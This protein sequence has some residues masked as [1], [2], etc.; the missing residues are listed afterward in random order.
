[1]NGCSEK[2][3]LI[4]DSHRTQLIG[5]LATEVNPS[6]ILVHCGD[7]VDDVAPLACR[8]PRRMLCVKGNNDFCS[9]APREVI[10]ALNGF[11]V[12]VTHGDAFGVRN[13]LT[14]IAEAARVRNCSVVF[15]GHTHRFN[16]SVIN[17]VRLI[18]PGALSYG[19]YAEVVFRGTDA[20]CEHKHIDR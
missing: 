3:I 9:S 16:D 5:R 15:F 7:G 20:L 6:T 8:Y 14:A 10:L 12:F 17:G 19:S 4:S 1:M 2:I 11:N 13:G 18:N